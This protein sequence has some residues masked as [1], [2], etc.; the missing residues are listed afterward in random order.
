MAGYGLGGIMQTTKRKTASPMARNGGQN[1]EHRAK[2]LDGKTRAD[3]LTP[4]VF[5]KLPRKRRSA[6]Q[7]AFLRAVMAD[8]SMSPSGRLAGVTLLTHHNVD[9]GRCFPSYETIAEKAGF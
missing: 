9:D 7:W 4:Q 6:L 1:T 3:T 5:L 2:G 8:S